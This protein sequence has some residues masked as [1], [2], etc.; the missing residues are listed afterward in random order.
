MNRTACITTSLVTLL[1]AGSIAQAGIIDTQDFNGHPATFGGW[2]CN[3]NQEVAYDENTNQYIGV[4]YMDFWG[5]TLSNSE[6]SSPVNT[7]YTVEGQTYFTVKVRMYA[8]DN[9][10]GEPMDPNWFPLVL[11][12]TDVGDPENWTDDASVYFVGAG[13]PQI[14]DGWVTY[15]Y[16]ID[17]PTSEELPPGWGGT[18]AEDP[19]TFEPILPPGRT[20]AN[21]LAS[22]DDVRFTTFVPGSFYSSSF[23]E[24]GFDDVHIESA[25]GGCPSDFDG[26]GFVD[27]EDFTAFVAAFEAGTDNADFDDSGFVDLDDYVAFV[28]AFESGC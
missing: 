21:V 17:D 22:I 4:P 13:M 12:L 24:V 16:V 9:W 6:P 7:D 18:G 5:I 2:Y 3:G 28:L 27:L 1:A 14:A 8:L 23:W 15:T 19:D 26:S 11:Q 20:F 25:G 10:F